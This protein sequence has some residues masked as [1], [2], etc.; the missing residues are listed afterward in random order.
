VEPIR[1]I[2][3]QD[4]DTWTS[5][6]PDIPRWLAV[7]ETFEEARQ[8]AEEGVRFALERDDVVVEHFWPY[9]PNAAPSA[10]DAVA[11]AA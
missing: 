2:H 5:E 8:L 11:P 9:P 3:R 4:E 6:S 7:A 10:S 1:V